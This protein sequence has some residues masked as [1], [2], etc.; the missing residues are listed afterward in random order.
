M[1]PDPEKVVAICQPNFLPWLGYFE[2]GH[3]ADVYVMLDDV[4]YPRREWV[5]RNKILSGSP[6]GWMWLTV[7]LKKSSQTIAINKVEVSDEAP[8][9]STMLKSL[10][11]VYG[12]APFFSM[13]YDELAALLARPWQ[14]LVDF[15]LGLIRWFCGKMGIHD[16][17]ALSSHLNVQLARDDKLVEICERLGATIYLANNGSKGYIDPSKFHHRG[18]GFVFQDYQHPTYAVN[19]YQFVPYLSALDLLFWHGPDALSIILSGR[20]PNWRER[21]TY[22]S[23]SVS[24]VGE[25]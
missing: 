23:R 15:N 19:G 18:I 10:R 14:Y 13:Y 17:L 24:V 21:V 2:M 1:M 12:R 16:N 22:G 20:D 4:Q 5:N 11:H 9:A 25:R 8:W 6:P 3:R 7:P